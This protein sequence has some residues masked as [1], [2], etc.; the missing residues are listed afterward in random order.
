LKIRLRRTVN[1][2][3]KPQQKEL[4]TGKNTRKREIL[5]IAGELFYFSAMIETG[6]VDNFK[7]TCGGETF[8]FNT[9][10]VQYDKGRKQYPFMTCVICFAKYRND[11]V[12][13]KGNF[14][15][16][17]QGALSEEWVLDNRMALKLN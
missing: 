7:C 10:N 17:R 9:R 16:F 2:Q 3:E 8:E 12:D 4:L 5:D 14:R 1:T 15:I 13:E 11:G 6:T